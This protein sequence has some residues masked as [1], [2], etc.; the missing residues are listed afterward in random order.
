[1]L[2]KQMKVMNE[3]IYRIGH[4]WRNLTDSL[5]DLTNYFQELLIHVPKKDEWNDLLRKA[6]YESFTILMDNLLENKNLAFFAQT[7]NDFRRGFINY[8]AFYI[9]MLMQDKI[10]SFIKWILSDKELYLKCVKIGLIKVNNIICKNQIK[11]IENNQIKY[12]TYLDKFF[13]RDNNPHVLKL[14]LRFI[15]YLLSF[16]QNF[17]YTLKEI[18]DINNEIFD[19]DFK[20]YEIFQ[21]CYEIMGISSQ[22]YIGLIKPN[23]YIRPIIEYAVII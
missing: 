4:R 20:Y 14:L 22:L 1:M 23:T 9:A 2:Q 5:V 7:E 10:F 19:Q 18:F 17:G 12:T 13:N 11:I 3:L 21:Q 6:I 15:I 16:C 8:P